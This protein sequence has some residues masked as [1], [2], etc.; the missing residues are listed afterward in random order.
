MKKLTGPI[1]LVGNTEMYPDIEYATGFR[2]PDPLVYLQTDKSASLIVSELEYGRAVQSVKEIDVYCPRTLGLPAK[3][4]G[5]LSEWVLA[6]LSKRRVR[7]VNVSPSFP[8]GIAEALKS[9][10]I[11]VLVAKSR[12]F[13]EREIKN[14]YEVN[15]IRESQQAA[16][17]AMRTAV[18]MISN[19][20]PSND[21]VL[22][23]KGKPLTSENIKSVI[24]K[25]LFDHN[26]LGRDTIAAGGKQAAS[27]HE[28]GHGKLRAGEAIV[29]DI[30][31]RNMDHGYWGDLTRTV[32]KGEPSKK[33][34]EIYRAVKAAQEE[35]LKKVRPGVMCKTIHKAAADEMK[36]RGFK[37]RAVDGKSEGFI[38]SVG[39]GVGLSIHEE[40]SVSLNDYRLKKGNII[41]IE[42][43][44]YYPDIG[45]VRIEDTIEVTGSGWKYL[46]PC[47]KKFEI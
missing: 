40:P 43:G 44:L 17:I 20:I 10:G 24:N 12:L 14:R 38:H 29:I 16:V 35:A 34:K 22:K 6:I 32:V 23:Y 28:T 33:I 27:P 7:R 46:V 2:A 5:R 18:S 47:E 30:F 37:T 9:A 21:G 26:C 45:G 1:L 13:P 15:R 36:K 19:S 3:K 39:H 42:P 8:V 25:T 4:S 31:P 41:T 11:K